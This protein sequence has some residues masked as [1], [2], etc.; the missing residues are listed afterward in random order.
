MND[1]F[2]ILLKDAIVKTASSSPNQEDSWVA[3]GNKMRK[4]KSKR[5]F[6]Y[7]SM[8][9]LVLLFLGMAELLFVQENAATNDY[10]TQTTLELN[11]TK[12]YYAGLIDEKFNQITKTKN[13]DKEYFQL[14]FDEMLRLDQEY[15]MYLTDSKT[16]GFQEDIVRAMIENQRR[17][18]QLLNRLENEIQKVQNYEKRKITM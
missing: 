4:Q 5:R 18:L 17:K 2:E 16:Y 15:K 12:F 3:I 14:F 11:E 8:A 6:L 10:Y 7:W 1:N 9:A 13:L